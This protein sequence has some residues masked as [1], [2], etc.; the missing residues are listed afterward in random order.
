MFEY[1]KKIKSELILKLEKELKDIEEAAKSSREYAITDEI[2]SE[3]KY[4][5]RA[6]EASYLASAQQG[7]VE[8][9]KLDLQMLTDLELHKSEHVELGSLV[10]VELN[11]KKQFF[12]ISPNLG[13]E[14][15]NIDE[16]SF[17]VISVFSPIG[18]EALNLSSGESF[19]VET[20][21][22]NRVYKIL[23]IF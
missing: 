22:E 21:K 2:K 9:L 5:T 4:D 1:K 23:E 3:G 14:I 7:R 12:F 11:S 17:L 15:I 19:E 6:I 20:P 13:G 8:E 18:S 16:F 10:H